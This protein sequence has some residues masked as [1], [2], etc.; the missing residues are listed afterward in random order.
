VQPQDSAASPTQ[1]QA[2]TQAQ[3]T[4][5]SEQAKQAVQQVNNL[6]G[7]NKQNVYATFTKDP[8]TGIEVIKFVDQETKQTVSQVPSK[9][10]LAIAESL[11]ASS[12][13]GQ[14]VNTTA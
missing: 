9:A 8:A 2:L 14:L 3:P 10:I 6:L 12:N 7:Q 1:T 11:Q 4:P 5:S 13:S